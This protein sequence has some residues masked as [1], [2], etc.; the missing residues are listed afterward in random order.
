MKIKKF[1][2]SDA[3]L[4]LAIVYASNGKPGATLEKIIALGDAIN[5]AVFNADELESGLR[6]LTSGKYIKE[7]N[8]CFS[9]ALKVRRAFAKIAARG[10][11]VEK[12]LEYLREF[13][14][15]ASPVAEQPQIN[16]LKYE[17]FSAEKFREAVNKYLSR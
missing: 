17:G 12:E 4:L 9:A 8:G 3:W 6:R 7:E 15:A 11:T 16:N 5:H 13:I 2:W 1:N 10:R 14:G